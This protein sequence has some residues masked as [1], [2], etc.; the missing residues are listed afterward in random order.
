M[1]KWIYSLLLLMCSL[2]AGTAWGGG[3]KGPQVVVSIKPIHSLI[4]GVMAGVGEPRL[5]LTGG[6]TPHGYALRPSE[7]KALAAADLVIWVGPELESF[8]I[9]PLASLGDKARSLVLFDALQ[10]RLLPIR[11]GGAWEEHEHHEP[12][13]HSERGM[14][15]PHFWLDPALGKEIVTVAAAALIRI[16]PAHQAVYRENVQQL[17]LKLDA[18]DAELKQILAPVREVPYVVFHDA[19]QYF[20][21]AY[22]LRSVGAIAIDPERKPGAR[23]ILEIRQKIRSLQARCVFSEPQFEPKLIATII[24]DTGA[25]TG[26]LDPLGAELPEGPDTYF[27]LLH[28]LAKAL[29]EGLR[30]QG[31]QPTEA[32]NRIQ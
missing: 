23:R 19:Y 17:L 32:G 27:E 25:R 26:T 20:E 2:L 7:A 13:G 8:L 29:V 31:V 11:Q 5:L 10:S 4:A 28:Q 14:R 6:A 16:D 15:N 30:P 22:N 3:D 24:E 12:A 9:K 21:E 1:K 18:L